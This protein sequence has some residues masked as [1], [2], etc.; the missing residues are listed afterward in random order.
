MF[1]LT[2]FAF[3]VKESVE[4]VSVKQRYDGLK[5]MIKCVNELFPRLSLSICVSF[6]SLYGICGFDIGSDDF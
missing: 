4:I 2:A 3:F 6:E 5:V 1:Y